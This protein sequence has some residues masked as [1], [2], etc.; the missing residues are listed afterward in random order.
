MAK[1]FHRNLRLAGDSRMF[2]DRG[3]GTDSSQAVTIQKPM[4]KITSST[5]NLAAATTEAITLTCR[6]ATANSVIAHHVDG[7]GNGDPV[8]SK[9]TPT[10]GQIVFTVLN[11]D[12]SN[13]CNAAYT[14]S[15]AIISSGSD[16]AI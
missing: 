5:T 2:L 8:M 14:I 16:D 13:A 1:T 7:G 15:Y 10:A 12:Q 11:A 9:V 6:Y 3:T 4:G